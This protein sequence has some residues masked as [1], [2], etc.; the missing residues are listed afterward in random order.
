MISKNNTIVPGSSEEKV[1]YDAFGFVVL[2]QVFSSDQMQAV[3]DAY[4]QGCS[5]NGSP[6]RASR[7][8]N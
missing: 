4:E 8:T 1:F 2:R 3:V 7:A 6:K 5:S